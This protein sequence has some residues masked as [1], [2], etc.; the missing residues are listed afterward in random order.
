MD[1][2]K[3]MG[4]KEF[5]FYLGRL[6]NLLTNYNTFALPYYREKYYIFLFYFFIQQSHFIS[7][8]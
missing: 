5:Y 2:N 7:T 1:D 8:S 4:K 3:Y 6:I